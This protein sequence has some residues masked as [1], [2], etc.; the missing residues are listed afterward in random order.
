GA[1]GLRDRVLRRRDERQREER[2]EDDAVEGPR[3][4][5]HS[6][7]TPKQRSVSSQLTPAVPAVSHAPVLA[8][9]WPAP[10]T[11]ERSSNVTKSSFFMVRPSPSRRRAP[12]GI[13]AA[14]ARPH[15]ADERGG[16][17]RRRR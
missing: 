6:Q 7:L 8:D 1:R 2:G 4:R 17:R 14:S 15:R 5:G 16:R 3:G 9:A 12:A 11:S 13:P 10:P